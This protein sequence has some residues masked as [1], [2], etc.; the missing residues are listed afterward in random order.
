[1]LETLAVIFL[2]LWLLGVVGGV[3]LGGFIHVVLIVAL[4][5]VCVK[6]LKQAS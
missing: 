2:I 3:S 4:V 1:M 5:L 6:L